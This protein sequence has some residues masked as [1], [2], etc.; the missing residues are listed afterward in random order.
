MR[1]EGVVR[2]GEQLERLTDGATLSRGTG[3]SYGDSSL[4][5]QRDDVVV[6]TVLAD[7]L[8]EFDPASGRLTAEAGLSLDALNQ[9]S[10]PAAG[11]RR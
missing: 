7:R 6:D 11:S 3:R 1:A 8:L 10:L 4:P 5:A 9:I 2:H